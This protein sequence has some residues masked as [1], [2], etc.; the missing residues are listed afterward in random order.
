MCTDD[1]TGA[2]RT[3]NSEVNQV[4]SLT[5]IGGGSFRASGS[6][7]VSEIINIHWPFLQ[8]KL[9]LVGHCVCMHAKLLQS[10]LILCNCMNCSL[11]VPLSVEILQVRILE[12]VA[13]FSSRGSS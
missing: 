5:H 11:L 2:E 9:P 7:L 3:A 10:C 12:W 13:M 6:L 4:L 8:P 1:M